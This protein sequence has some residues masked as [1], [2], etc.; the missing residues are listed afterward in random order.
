L[1]KHLVHAVFAVLLCL[2]AMI[3]YLFGCELKDRGTGLVAAAL[4]A[5]VPGACSSS[6]SRSVFALHVQQ[7]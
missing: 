4:M 1:Q 5:V 6:S 7:R 2:Q 3:A